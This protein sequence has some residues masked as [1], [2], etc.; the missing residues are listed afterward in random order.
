MMNKNDAGQSNGVISLMLA[1][2]A[3]M[4][5]QCQ[6]VTFI[7]ECLDLQCVAYC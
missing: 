2:V 3:F 7:W 4:Y 6:P 5:S 1:N